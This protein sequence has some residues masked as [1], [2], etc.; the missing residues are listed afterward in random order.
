VIK[1][2]V[3][4]VDD[5]PGM[6]RAVERVLSSAYEVLACRSA[7][8]AL[9]RAPSFSPDLAL[10][11]VRMPELSGFELMDRLK[12]QHPDL[13]FIFMT[14]SVDQIDAT[15][16][17]A[18]RVKA[19]YFIQKPFDREVL[20]ALIERCVE[21]RRLS[22]ENQRHVSRLESELAEARAFQESLLPRV[23]AESEGI[24]IEAR[25][26]P[27]AEIGGDFYD[28]SPAGKG[29]LTMLIADV[30]GHGA[31]AAML[32]GIVKSAFDASHAEGTHPIDVVNR[33]ASGLRGFEF[34][35]FVTLLCARID[36]ATGTIEYVN[37]GHPPAVL[38]GPGRS[39]SLLDPTGPLIS[40]ALAPS[41]WTER[42]VEAG[43]DWRL[44]FYTDGVTE[45]EGAKG[46]LGLRGVLDQVARHP[47]GEGPLLDGILEAMS[48]GA[49][50][51]GAADDLTLLTARP[52]APR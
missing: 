16:V 38:W 43:R 34:R 48:P 20:L 15:L 5:E 32:T 31:S 22:H 29:L 6:L 19:F 17:R 8:N 33:I 45:S 46:E 1:P 3:L 35:R 11:D 39:P 23:P 9:G 28:F 13:D 42:R 10:L 25:Y 50:G 2:R 30:A 51:V 36:V 52:V 4:V 12:A 21:L 27:C 24:R 37:A 40:S 41:T 7:L 14:G 18:I 26:L 44:L 49:P 47:G